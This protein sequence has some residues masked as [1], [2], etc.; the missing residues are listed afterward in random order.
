MAHGQTCK[1][2]NVIL[3]YEYEWQT[4]FSPFQ[5]CKHCRVVYKQQVHLVVNK[6]LC[7]QKKT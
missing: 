4:L 5:S 2:T 3:K 6:T 1:Y 7:Q